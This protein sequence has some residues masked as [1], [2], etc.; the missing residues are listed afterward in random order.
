MDGS[1]SIYRNANFLGGFGDHPAL[2]HWRDLNLLAIVAAF[3]YLRSMLRDSTKRSPAD[4][5]FYS[6]YLIKQSGK[7]TFSATGNYFTFD[8]TL[9]FGANGTA[10]G[11]TITSYGVTLYPQPAIGHPTHALFCKAPLQTLT[12]QSFTAPGAEP[13]I[14]ASHTAKFVGTAE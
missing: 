4:W 8:V 11:G 10:T 3:F 12:L 5:G 6:D 1:G 2:A 9:D 14:N 13:A 7:V